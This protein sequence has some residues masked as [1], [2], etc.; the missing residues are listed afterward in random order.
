MIVLFYEFDENSIP[1]FTLSLRCVHYSA[2][3]LP[4]NHGIE[5]AKNELKAFLITCTF[6]IYQVHFDQLF[7]IPCMFPYLCVSWFKLTKIY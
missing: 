2:K 6:E 7:F 5:H 4:H 3:V 1:S